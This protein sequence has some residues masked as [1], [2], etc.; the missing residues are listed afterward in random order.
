MVRCWGDGTKGQLGTGDTSA[1]GGFQGQMA[2]LVDLGGPALD[3]VAGQYHACALMSGGRVRCWGGNESGQLGIGS[4]QNIGD[5][6]GEM[7][8]QDAFLYTKPK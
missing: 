5:E 4:T 7:P 8:P 3:L 6:P 1:I 2:P